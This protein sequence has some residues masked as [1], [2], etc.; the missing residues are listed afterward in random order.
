MTRMYTEAVGLLAALASLLSGFLTSP[1]T[2][3]LHIL[4]HQNV[5]GKR[6]CIEHP[7]IIFQELSPCHCRFLLVEEKEA[8]LTTNEIT[9]FVSVLR[10]CAPRPTG[11]ESGL[12]RGMGT[13]A[14][15]TPVCPQGCLCVCGQGGGGSRQLHGHHT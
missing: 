12:Q 4:Y 7:V 10:P 14:R 3:P 8:N 9:T 6:V 5:P 15:N 11:R 13:R 1:P 2:V